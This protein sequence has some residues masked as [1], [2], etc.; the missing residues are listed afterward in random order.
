MKR[1]AMLV[2]VLLITLLLVGCHGEA[3]S[4]DS[5]GTRLWNPTPW[6]INPTEGPLNLA[7]TVNEDGESCT[8][9]GVLSFE[10]GALVIPETLNGLRVTAIAN[11]AFSDRYD[12]VT[13]LVLPEGLVSI[14]KSAFGSF[15]DL[16]SVSLP[17]TLRYVGENA[18]RSCDSITQVHISS[19]DDYYALLYENAEASPTH[20]GGTLLLNGEPLTALVIPGEIDE[21][22]AYL[23]RWCTSLTSVQLHDGVKH[24]R[25]YAF[26][27]CTALTSV[28]IPAVIALE[29]RAFYECSSLARIT[30]PHTLTTIGARAFS[31]CTSLE[32]LIVPASVKQIGECPSAADVYFEGTALAWH[33]CFDEGVNDFLSDAHLW[34]YS[35][36]CPPTEGQYW[37]YGADGAPQHW[38]DP[39]IPPI[40][41][42]DEGGR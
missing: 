15:R 39:A 9:T 29:E 35:E 18:F 21:I 36:E 42:R 8:V 28:E 20:A 41:G 13:S 24:V 3:P 30:L 11:S 25:A 23:F 33:S 34:F 38:F 5:T 31:R 26:A 12:G 22:G 6:S 14:G 19:L 17:S 40:P 32:Y 4:S 1:Y 27:G 37:Y 16:T 2:I 7:Y 10:H